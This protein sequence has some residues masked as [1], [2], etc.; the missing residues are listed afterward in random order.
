MV[1]PLKSL[2]NVIMSSVSGKEAGKKIGKSP[3]YISQIRSGD[4][5]PTEETLATIA[6]E[7]GVADRFS[8]LVLSA[9]LA[10][11]QSPEFKRDKDGM[12][13]KSIVESLKK[14]SGELSAELQIKKSGRTFEDF[15]DSFYPLA[16]VSGDKREEWG[17]KI[18]V[19][20]LTAYSATP[21]DT[22]WLPNLGLRPD[23]IKHIDK[24][25]LLLSEN[26]L[27]A[28]FA[29]TNLLV[30]G[31]PAANHLA[32][33]INSSAIFR[34]NYSKDT[35]QVIED[36][37]AKARTLTNAQLVA[38]QEEQRGWLKKRMRAFFTGGIIDPTHPDEYAVAKYA[39]IAREIQLDFG[40]L[41]FG[42]NPYY[43]MMCKR[44]GRK[45]DHKYISIMAAGIHHP[46]TAHALKL[47]G[48]D[49]QENGVFA[50]HP[51][52]GVVRV[53]LDLKVPFSN[54]TL[55]AL[56]RWEDV[57]D[58]ERVVS[59]NQKA[60]LTREFRVIEEKVTKGQLRNL[61][62]EKGHAAECRRLIEML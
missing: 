35:E 40:V 55:K 29:K 12:L 54:R 16:L 33:I 56:C 58:N 51:Y 8:E 9:T 57:A 44:E 37:I 28:Q 5:V 50:K 19:A 18:N 34:F 39:Q 1:K 53:E 26:E 41:T 17:T 46:G 14:I 2:L 23:I 30:I 32:R 42:A 59:E 13:K 24:N 27:I 22:R 62:L 60:D 4:Q 31:S 10:K 38:Y 52:G 21:A 15:P 48:R 6:N 11:L 7:F 47:L 61:A 36:V 43:Q 25:F 49:C 3:S 20:D 45:C